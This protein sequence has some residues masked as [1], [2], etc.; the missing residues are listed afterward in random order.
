MNTLNDESLMSENILEKQ[1]TSH[2][3]IIKSYSLNEVPDILE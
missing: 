1:E 2:T 3:I